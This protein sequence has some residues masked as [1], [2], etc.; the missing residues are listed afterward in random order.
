M[1]SLTG[2]LDYYNFAAM[3]I[4]KQVLGISVLLAIASWFIEAAIHTIYFNKGPFLNML[5]LT[6]P[7]HE[8]YSRSTQFGLILLFG[9]LMSRAMAKQKAARSDLAKVKKI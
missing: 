4:D 7:G 8:M 3:K 5:I 9:I 6:V 2:K 1:H